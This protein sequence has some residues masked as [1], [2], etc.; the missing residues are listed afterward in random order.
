MSGLTQGATVKPVFR[1]QTIRRLR[2]QGKY[3][4]A[5]LANHEQKWQPY[6]V[7][8]YSAERSDHVCL[9]KYIPDTY[10]ECLQEDN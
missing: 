4:F 7:G 5:C 1:D 9:Q 10:I 2:G 6:K 3:H 8:P